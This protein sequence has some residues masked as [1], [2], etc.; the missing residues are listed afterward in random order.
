[1]KIDTDDY[2]TIEEVMEAIGCSQ[3][4]VYRAI[5]AAA[6]DGIEVCA[7][8]FGKRLVVRKMLDAVRARYFPFGSERRSVM[9]VEFG[10]QGG[11]TKAANAKRRPRR[12]S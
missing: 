12:T 3:R 9:A 6:A 5:D 7:Y 11:L 2:L 10:R 8:I 4:S 1:M